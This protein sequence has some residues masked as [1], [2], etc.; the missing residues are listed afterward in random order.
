MILHGK[1]ILDAK[2]AALINILRN[3]SFIILDEEMCHRWD[4]PHTWLGLHLYI[5]NTTALTI[6]S[7]E[8][9]HLVFNTYPTTHIFINYRIKTYSNR[10][11][12]THN[13]AHNAHNAHDIDMTGAHLKLQ[14]S[15]HTTSYI[16]S[17]RSTGFDLTTASFLKGHPTAC[18]AA[19]VSPSVP[20]FII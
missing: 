20:P 17:A 9:A 13:T 10:T 7:T 6:D 5:I 2:D 14:E 16:Y 19:L 11:P 18:G 4:L 15:L 12:N 1:T 3:G 8:A